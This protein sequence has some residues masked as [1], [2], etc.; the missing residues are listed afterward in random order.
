MAQGDVPGVQGFV[1]MGLLLDFYGGLLTERQLL[2]CRLYFAENLSLGEI[3]AELSISRQA[4]HDTVRRAE[5]VLLG[6]EDKLKLVA[7]FVEQQS[8]LRH[9]RDLYLEGK[10]PEVLALLERLIT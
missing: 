1:R 3:A 9:L 6:Y 10:T 5:Q 7:R 4:V 2:A 8:E